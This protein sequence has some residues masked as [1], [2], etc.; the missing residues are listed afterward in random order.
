MVLVLNFFLFKRKS[1]TFVFIC[2]TA[3]TPWNLRLWKETQIHNNVSLWNTKGFTLLLWEY[4]P[5]VI[6]WKIKCSL[7][8]IEQKLQVRLVCNFNVNNSAKN[9]NA[10]NRLNRNYLITK[11]KIISHIK[12]CRGCF[13]YSYR[14]QW[15]SR[16]S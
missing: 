8:L 3:L 16:C 15:C 5:K 7:D 1:N 14:R 10:K 2:R 11:N 4:F 13:C 6:V 9:V 12:I